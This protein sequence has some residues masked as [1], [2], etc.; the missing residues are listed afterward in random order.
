MKFVAKFSE[1]SGQF[2]ANMGD[3]IRGP[4]GPQGEKGETGPQGPQGEKGET[5]PQGPQGEK[6]ETGP[7][8]KDAPQ[9]VIR[10]SEQA[11]TDAQ[12]AQAR[13]NIG[14]A[15][16]GEVGQLKDDLADVWHKSDWFFG[17]DFEWETGG[18]TVTT[19]ENIDN[20]NR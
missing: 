1:N 4:Q 3:W 5:G 6:G 11:L 9:D 16:S 19:G 18:I 15:S 8:G 7:S 12:Q 13:S 10:Y 2:N 20:D 14:A 17:I